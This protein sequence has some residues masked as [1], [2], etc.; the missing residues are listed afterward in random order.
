[1]GGLA[2]TYDPLTVEEFTSS[3]N[4]GS[5]Y[6]LIEKNRSSVVYG[7]TNCSFAT[8]RYTAAT[9]LSCCQLKQLHILAEHRMSVTA[10][11]IT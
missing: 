1:M 2:E 11:Q 7:M 9:G 6:C 5:P 10:I 3:E 8:A 4:I